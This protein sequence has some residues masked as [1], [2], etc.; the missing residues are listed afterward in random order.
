MALSLH[1]MSADDQKR[2]G[3]NLI[4]GILEMS[5]KHTIKIV[6]VSFLLSSAL[7]L[8]AQRGAGLHARRGLG[9][10]T[11][12]NLIDAVP[13]SDLDSDEEAHLAFMREEEKLARDVYMAL[14]SEY[15]AQIF[16]NISLS[17]ERH[18][19]AIKLLLDR[20]GLPDPAEGNAAGVF[21]DPGLQKLYSDLVASGKDSL[22]EAL[23]VG[24]TIE[25]LDYLDLEEALKNTDNDDLKI[26]YRNLQDG[27][28]NHMRAFVF[29][30]EAMGESYDAQFIE[31]AT[32][33]EILSSSNGARMGFGRKRN[34]SRTTGR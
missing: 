9:D 4:G 5:V 26:V 19:N 20:Y 30:L 22:L 11:C 16:W 28:R 12:Q 6:M 32:L 13:I 21:S 10:G 2:I 33:E 34:T 18:T 29:Q 31:D 25:D 14:Y 23:R 15:G 24:A 7:P 8:W 1:P 27:T 3:N 17:E